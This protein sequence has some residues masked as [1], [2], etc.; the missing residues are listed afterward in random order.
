MIELNFRGVA[1]LSDE[2]YL[3]VVGNVD[4]LNVTS[5]GS[6]D[7][8]GC[9]ISCQASSSNA[10][11][12]SLGVN[13]EGIPTSSSTGPAMPV[14]PLFQ[15]MITETFRPNQL[16]LRLAVFVP[17][18][19]FAYFLRNWQRTLITVRNA[20]NIANFIYQQVN[21][22][23]YFTALVVGSPDSS[24]WGL[25]AEEDWKLKASVLFPL[26]KVA[27]ERLWGM[28]G[29]DADYIVAIRNINAF[30]DRIEGAD[31]IT[32]ATGRATMC[33]GMLYHE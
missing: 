28:V 26:I 18:E 17:D 7:D 11:A 24:V 8:I 33:K 1:W 16:H 20:I 4:E 10:S 12:R 30:G 29:W 14:Q 19:S 27:K 32:G 2:A 23:V 5:F 15:R 9:G 21:I 6:V 31:G 3:S 13:S 25:Y 22:S